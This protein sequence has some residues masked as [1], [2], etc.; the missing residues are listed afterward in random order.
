MENSVM[1]AEP[2]QKKQLVRVKE[3]VCKRKNQVRDRILHSIASTPLIDDLMQISKQEI[4]TA[5]YEQVASK[6]EAYNFIIANGLLVEFELF[7]IE[8]E[9]RHHAG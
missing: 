4:I 2:V 3:S 5:L 1:I 7:I 6:L 8:K 9:R